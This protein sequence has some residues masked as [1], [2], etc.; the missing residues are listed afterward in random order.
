MTMTAAERRAFVAALRACD[1]ASLTALGR[2]LRAQGGCVRETAL[3]LGMPEQ[4]L[5][6]VARDVPAVR[7]VL[8][9]GSIG[10]AG[11]MRYRQR[12]AAGK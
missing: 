4:T 5:W 9:A 3:A 12:R 10:R 2:A 8:A 1:R 11:V 6:S 7:Q